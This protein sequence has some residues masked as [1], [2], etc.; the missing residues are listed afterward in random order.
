MHKAARLPASRCC[1]QNGV[2]Q[3]F[4]ASPAPETTWKGQAENGERGS[5]EHDHHNERAERAHKSRTRR[6]APVA[7]ATT[8]SR[9]SCVAGTP[10][11]HGI[12]GKYRTGARLSG[13]TNGSAIPHTLASISRRDLG[14]ACIK[15]FICLQNI[16]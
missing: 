5:H 16:V 11:Y 2:H 7:H 4:D 6:V 15:N 14:R 1:A 8:Y 3:A 12:V 9:R 10:Q 13:P